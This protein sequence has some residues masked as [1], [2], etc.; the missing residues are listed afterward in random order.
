MRRC[1]RCFFHKKIKF[2]KR[3]CISNPLVQRIILEQRNVIQWKNKVLFEH[4]R[5]SVTRCTNKTAVAAT[6]LSLQI[7][8]TPL[9]RNIRSFLR[10]I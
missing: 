2:R 3:V 9:H 6:V 8:L 1:V 5:R 10:C 4:V 7:G